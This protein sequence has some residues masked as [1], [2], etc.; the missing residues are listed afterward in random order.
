MVLLRGDMDALPVAEEVDVPFRSTVPGV[1]H[2]C[3]HDLH[4]AMLAGAAR[5]LA[6]RREQLAGD[7]VFMFQ[8]GEEGFDGARYMLEEGVL[9]A[10]GRPAGRGVRAARDEQPDAPRDGGVAARTA[11]GGVRRGVRDRQ[12][13]RRPRVDPAPVPGPDR[14]GLR[15]GQR[16]A[17]GDDAARSTRSPPHVLTIGSFH[18]GTKRNIIPETATFE[19]TVRT[20]DRSVRQ[21]LADTLQRVCEGVAAAHGVEVEVRYE[22]E[23]PVTVN[24]RAEAAFALG[25]AEDMFGAGAALRMPNPI[26]GSEDFSRVIA[27]VPGAMLFLG[28]V[29]DDRDPLRGAQ[30]PRA[31]GRLRRLGTGPGHRPLRNARR[32]A[33]RPGLKGSPCSEGAPDAAGPAR[34]CR[35]GPAV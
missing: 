21:V 24:D 13:A 28:A 5:V 23:Y 14:R 6:G 30:Q 25:V 7:V 22:E 15:D 16:A 29:V 17:G 35:A 1:M 20:F 12:G 27:A 8:P 9:D 31:A 3:G 33:A 34:R 26:T 4:T 10:A 11:D 18:A 32:A 19:A 2:A